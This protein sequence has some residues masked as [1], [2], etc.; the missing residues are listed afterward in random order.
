[1]GI[2][3]ARQLPTPIHS[4]PALW[5][6]QFDGSALRMLVMRMARLP[7]LSI[8]SAEPIALVR[9]APAGSLTGSAGPATRSVDRLEAKGELRRSVSGAGRDANQKFTLMGGPH[10]SNEHDGASRE[11][12]PGASGERRTADLPHPPPRAT[13][14]RRDGAH[15]CRR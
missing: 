8:G 4:S 6:R 5:A 12:Q 15:R 10:R 9:E 3:Q 7:S 13:G 1:M 14:R 11:R 2:I